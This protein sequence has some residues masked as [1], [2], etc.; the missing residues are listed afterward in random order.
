MTTP[1]LQWFIDVHSVHATMSFSFEAKR[2]ELEAIKLYAEVEEVQSFKSQLKVSPLSSG[3][4][5][6]TGVLA[7]KAVQASVVD[8]G[9][10]PASVEENF[11]VEYWPQETIEE[12]GQESVSLGE[13]A[14]EPIAAGR[15]AIGSFLCELFSVSLDPYPRN[16]GDAFDW[17]PAESEERASP[18]ADLVRLRK[19]K[20][21]GG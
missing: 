11:S 14:P 10:V 4:F 8:L 3:K 16:P 12:R 18:F 6:V 13:D 7:V 20:P 21:D 17:R 2:E 15:I 1:P 9:P 5:R 19:K